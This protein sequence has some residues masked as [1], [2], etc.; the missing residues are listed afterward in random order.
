MS[1]L[2]PR[3]AA[4]DDGGVVARGA[5]E[6]L[7]RY[8][9]SLESAQ[10]CGPARADQSASRPERWEQVI[11]EPASGSQSHE[12]VLPTPPGGGVPLPLAAFSRG[13]RQGGGEHGLGG[14]A[15]LGRRAAARGRQVAPPENRCPLLPA[16]VG[17]A[18]AM[19]P[20][21]TGGC[22]SA[23]R[24]PPLAHQPSALH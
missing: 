18:A 19:E 8:P 15:R 7:S 5:P 2:V 20:A 12:R 21:I 13:A 10:G 11:A 9:P 16:V 6:A 23:G 22:R 3:R 17:A 14:P 24:A 4:V 1:A